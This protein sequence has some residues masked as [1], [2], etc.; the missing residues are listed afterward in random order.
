MECTICKKIRSLSNWQ[1]DYP[2]FA[3]CASLGDGWYLPALKELKAISAQFAA[4]NNTLK[5]K[6]KPELES[7]WHWPSTQLA[8]FCAWIVYMD[9]GDTGNGMNYLYFYVRAV[10]AF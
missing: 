4:I 6:G 10:S 1:N 7:Y 8:D 2:A 3:W 9:N 5:A